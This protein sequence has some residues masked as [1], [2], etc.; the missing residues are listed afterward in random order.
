MTM[1]KLSAL[2]D[3]L[4]AALTHHHSAESVWAGPA[5]GALGGAARR[6]GD[7]RHPGDRRRGSDYRLRCIGLEADRDWTGRGTLVGYPPVEN[8]EETPLLF[9]LTSATPIT[10]RESLPGL[11]ITHP[12]TS[13]WRLQ[14]TVP[15]SPRCSR[16][17]TTALG[18][19]VRT[20]LLS[21]AETAT[22]IAHVWGLPPLSVPPTRGGEKGG[23][24]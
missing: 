7:Q 9:A 5:A 24:S 10:F 6:G 19:K 4:K 11:A 14:R 22:E 20:D 8:P 1:K 18:R 23:G 16:G 3:V 2:V 17:L 12:L 13:Q 21:V 15:R